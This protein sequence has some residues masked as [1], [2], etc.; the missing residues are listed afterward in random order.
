MTPTAEA[1]GP[2]DFAVRISAV[3]Q[4]RRRV[5]RI[6]LRVRDDRE[7]PFVRRDGEGYT[8]I[9]GFWK[10]EYFCK[11]GWTNGKMGP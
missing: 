6:P 1:S 4:K 8:L 2:H 11:R 7:R 5:H 9:C 10:T 3:R